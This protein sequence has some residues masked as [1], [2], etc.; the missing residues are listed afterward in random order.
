MPHGEPDGHGGAATDKAN[1]ASYADLPTKEGGYT[2]GKGATGPTIGAA[3]PPLPP[4]N[5]RIQND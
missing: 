2:G 5:R 1:C 4:R 3:P